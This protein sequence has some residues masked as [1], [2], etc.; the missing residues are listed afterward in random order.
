MAAKENFARRTQERLTALAVILPGILEV[1]NIYLANGYQT[2]PTPGAN[3]IND[4]DL[5]A[6][7]ITAAQ[8]FDGVTAIRQLGRLLGNQTTT[9]ADYQATLNR[10]RTDYR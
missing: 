10:L 6:L 9:P 5:T 7:G 8:L 2:L 4:G 1:D 3:P